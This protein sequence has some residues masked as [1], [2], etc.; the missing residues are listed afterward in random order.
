MNSG[1]ISTFDQAYH[2]QQYSISAGSRQITFDF[3]APTNFTVNSTM[4]WVDTATVSYCTTDWVYSPHL[5]LNLKL[6]HL[7]RRH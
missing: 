7:E 3:D 6:L 4:P 1:L 5:L 2:H